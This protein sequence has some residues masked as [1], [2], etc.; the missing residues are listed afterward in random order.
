VAVIL[1]V[2][3]LA[4]AAVF[5]EDVAHAV[6]QDRLRGLGIEDARFRVDQVTTRSIVIADFS[7]GEAMSFERLT[8]GFSV[9]D[10]LRGRVARIELTGLRMDMTQPGP[11]ARFRRNG[12]DTAGPRIDPRFLPTVDIRR[13]RLRFV[14]PTGLMT[15]TAGATLR[16]EADGE[17]A[18][19]AQASAMGPPGNVDVA[20][21]GTIRVGAQGGAT[22]SGRLR[23]TSMVLAAG[24]AVFKSLKVELPM[25]V[26]ATT[27][28]VTATVQ[29]GARFET[30]RLELEAGVSTGPISGSITGHLSS[31]LA[32]GGWFG[33]TTEIIVDAREVRTDFL[34]AERIAASLPMRINAGPGNVTIIFTREGRL[35]LDGVQPARNAPVTNVS[36][37]ILGRIGLSWSVDDSG[38]SA[39]IAVDHELSIG[40]E[41]ITIP[42]PTEVRATLGKIK[43]SGALAADGAY[44]G[45]VLI[46]TGQFAHGNRAL[47]ATGIVVRLTTGAGLAT[48]IARIT[49]DALRGAL[50][51]PVSGAYTVVATVRESGGGVAYRADISGLGMHK[52]RRSCRGVASRYRPRRRWRAAGRGDSGIERN[53]QC[54]GPDQWRRSVGVEERTGYRSGKA[55]A[56]QRR[57]RNG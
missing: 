47:E 41:P 43:S 30:K 57:R 1:A 23:A 48:P 29:Q 21:E 49:V 39:G 28:G 34:T 38:G 4:G 20:Y 46:D 22:A 24:R 53:S 26:V 44:I 25:S 15:V 6:L 54:Y 3:V 42:G 19:Q 55:A 27:A 14:I 45:R 16:P 11:W 51:T 36:S 31:V 50:P 40:P 35:A 52:T 2:T 17:L 8:V 9:G 18:F 33:G 13:A 12:D 7:S 37:T 32:P 56:R 5:R 10:V